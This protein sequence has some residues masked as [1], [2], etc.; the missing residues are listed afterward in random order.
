MTKAELEKLADQYQK[1]ADKAYYDYQ[2]TG[3]TRYDT[4]RRKNEDLAEAMRMAAAA[5][6]DHEKLIHLRA[7]ILAL[8]GKA[9][10]IRYAAEDQKE[11][12]MKDIVNELLSLARLSGLIHTEIGRYQLCCTDTSFSR[13]KRTQRRSRRSTAAHSTA[14]RPV[15]A[16]NGTT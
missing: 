1:K 12:R 2:E 3:V 4:A 15:A 5:K 8:V 16:Q 9:E 7:S 10:S 14:I 13:P 11:A 6:D